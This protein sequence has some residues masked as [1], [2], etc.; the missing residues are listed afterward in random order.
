MTYLLTK[1]LK[2]FDLVPSWA[3]VALIVVLLQTTSHF[4]M[5]MLQAR[6][7][8]ATANAQ[9]A[10]ATANAQ[11]AMRLTEQAAQKLTDQIAQDDHKRQTTRLASAAGADHSYA[12]LLNTIAAANARATSEG[13]SAAA[14]AEAATTARNLLGACAAEYRGV[15][16]DADQLADQVTGLQAFAAK[17][18][19]SSAPRAIELTP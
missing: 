2:G 13:A 7:D 6:A 4:R 9:T 15:A 11:A 10:Q 18:C 16:K 14:S 17:A 1:L 12:G 19:R 8:L 3:Y 5:G